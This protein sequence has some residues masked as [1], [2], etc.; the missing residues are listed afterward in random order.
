MDFRHYEREGIIIDIIEYDKCK[1]KL[2]L[3][4]L[5]GDGEL[6]RNLASLIKSN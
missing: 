4:K 5:S 6:T 1:T 2:K 3:K